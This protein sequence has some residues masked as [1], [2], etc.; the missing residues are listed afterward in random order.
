MVA[1]GLRI[2]TRIVNTEAKKGLKELRKD[3]KTAEKDLN[4]GAEGAQSLA[5]GIQAAKSGMSSFLSEIGGAAAAFLALL[6]VIISIV[7]AIKLVAKYDEQVNTDLQYLAFV[8]KTMLDNIGRALAS[9]IKP[10]VEWIIKAMYIILGVLGTIINLLFGI[11]IFKNTG[12]DAFQ[13]S[14]VKSEKTAKALKKQLAGFDEMNVLNDNSSSGGGGGAGAM[15]TPSFD[16][17]QFTSYKDEVFKFYDELGARIKEMDE[18]LANPEAFDKAYGNWGTLMYGVTQLMDGTFSTIH[19]TIEILAG[20]WDTIC[21]VLTGDWEKAW[22]GIKRTFSGAVEVI[23]GIFLIIAGIGNTV[24][25][26]IKGVALSVVDAIKSKWETLKAVFAGLWTAIKARF[27]D[28]MVNGFNNLKDKIVGA[29]TT[30]KD[31]AQTNLNNLKDGFK[32]VIN[33]IIDGINVL[34]RGLNKLKF[35]VPDWVPGIGGKKW[36]FN[37]SEIPHLASGGIVN[38]PGRGVMMGSY[39]AGEAGPEAVIPLDDS[40]MERLGSAIAR[41]MNIMNVTQLD[42]RTIQRQIQKVGANTA[43][44]RNG[45]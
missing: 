13:K 22:E 31:K 19:G 17:S 1:G 18:A 16:A 6:G 28:P 35:D 36:G 30:A 45:G 10:V 23:K 24:W 29:V 21:G 9:W 38:N 20:I 37:I 7:G 15:P 11:D 5:K 2:I 26:A 34:I 14:L 39:V 40:T 4:G 42:G 8:A 44:A 12:A 43:F 41:N 27:I 25:G 33:K 32:N 3:I